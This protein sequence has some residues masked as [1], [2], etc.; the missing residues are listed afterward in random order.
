MTTQLP[1]PTTTQL[2]AP[3]GN[4]Y[5]HRTWLDDMADALGAVAGIY[6]DFGVMNVTLHAVKA[7]RTQLNLVADCEVTALEVMTGGV[8]LVE[9]TDARYMPV[10]EAIGLAGGVT[11][12][13]QDKHYHDRD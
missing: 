13:A 1:A 8:R 12:V 4:G 6:R 7:G 5:T 10:F 2:P 9:A 11:E 3:T